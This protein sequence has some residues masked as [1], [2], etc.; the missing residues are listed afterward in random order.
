M[1]NNISA[2]Q[3]K[4]LLS[5]LNDG[6]KGAF[7]AIFQKYYSSLCAYSYRFVE[8]ADGEEIVQDILLWLWQNRTTFYPHTSL[9]SY[10]FRAVHHRCLSCIEQQSVKQ[11]IETLYWKNQLND[12][13]SGADEF[14]VEELLARIHQ[15]IEQLPPT[16][17]EAFILHRFKD[18]SYKEIAE[19]LNVSTKTVDYR[20][21]QALKLLRADLKDYF[22]LLLLLMA[23]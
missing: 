21:Q 9:A 19:Q 17:R 1:E 4:E 22:P 13:P 16:Y 3:D 10:L 14:Q 7:N 12:I 23:R 11:R 15:A 8:L 2:E 20:I 6:D 5:R 18:N